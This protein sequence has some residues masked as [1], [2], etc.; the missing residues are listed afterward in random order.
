MAKESPCSDTWDNEVIQTY[1]IGQYELHISTYKVEA[2]SI[3]LAIQCVLEGEG[4]LVGPSPEFSN[5]IDELGISAAENCELVQQLRE[6]G[7]AIEGEVVPSIA[8]VI[9]VDR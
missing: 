9:T 3:A 5:V 7:I 2:T 8:S 6:V 1:H 4:E